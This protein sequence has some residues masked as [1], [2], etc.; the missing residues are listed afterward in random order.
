MNCCD[1]NATS[2]A[3]TTVTQFRRQ[4]FDSHQE[5]KIAATLAKKYVESYGTKKEGTSAYYLDWKQTKNV[6]DSLTKVCV[7]IESEN[8]KAKKELLPYDDSGRSAEEKEKIFAQNVK[9]TIDRNRGAEIS[10]EDLK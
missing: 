1:D 2:Y 9:N 6:C 3:R 4:T 5:N 10:Q 8:S 7:A